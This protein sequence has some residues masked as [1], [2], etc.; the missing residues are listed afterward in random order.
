M[1][2][3]LEDFTAEMAV[4]ASRWQARWWMAGRQRGA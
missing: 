1:S 2:F 4:L 3:L